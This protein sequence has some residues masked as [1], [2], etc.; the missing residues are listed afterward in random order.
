MRAWSKSPPEQSNEQA[1]RDQPRCAA[2]CEHQPY[3]HFRGEQRYHRADQR[4]LGE[5]E[6]IVDQKMNVGN[7]G[8]ARD[9]EEKY[10]GENG[11]VDGQHQA[12]GVFPHRQNHSA[13]GN[14]N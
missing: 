1:N 8:F 10:P 4:T 3:R 5:A 12:P 9:L 13:P 11:D 6:M 14:G 7:V 2:Q